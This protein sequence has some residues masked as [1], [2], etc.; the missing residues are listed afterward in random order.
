[1][2]EPRQKLA[3]A[4]AIESML[5]FITFQSMLKAVV[6]LYFTVFCRGK[7]AIAYFFSDNICAQT[8]D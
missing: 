7:S 8:I 3:I 5:V 4:M 1:M 6:Y 2:F